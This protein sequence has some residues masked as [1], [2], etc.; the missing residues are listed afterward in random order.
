M[1]ELAY[2]VNTVSDNNLGGREKYRWNFI[3][4]CKLVL[5]FNVLHQFSIRVI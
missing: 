2:L 1:D 4:K 5:I 3:A